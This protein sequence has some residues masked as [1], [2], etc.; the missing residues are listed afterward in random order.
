[1]VHVSSFLALAAVPFAS[2]NNVLEQLAPEGQ[3]IGTNLGAQALNGFSIVSTAREAAA[4]IFSCLIVGLCAHSLGIGGTVTLRSKPGKATKVPRGA[5]KMDDDAQVKSHSRMVTPPAN[6]GSDRLAAAASSLVGEIYA[7]NAAKLPQMLDKV[8]RRIGG[9][10]VEPK[11]RDARAAQLLLSCV[12]ACAGKRCFREAI[13]AYDHF[14]HL[15]GDG[16]GTTWS[17]LLWSAVETGCWDRSSFFAKKLRASGEISQNDIVNLVRCV[18]YRWDLDEF[19]AILDE[20]NVAGVKLDVVTRN[21]TLAV[22]TSSGAMDF[23]AELVSRTADVPLDVITYN[24]LMKGYLL[25]EKP[26][27]CIRLYEQMRSDDVGPSDVTFGI[28]LD[29]CVGG[30]LLEE[31]KR[32]LD[33]LKASELVVNVVHYT[34]FIKGLVSA[35]SLSDAR[36][37]LAEMH[38]SPHTKPDMIAYSTLAKAYSDFGHVDDGIHLWRMMRSQGVEPDVILFNMVLRACCVNPVGGLKIREVFDQAM[39]FGFKPTSSTYSVL[40][41]ACA[42]SWCWALALD[43][44]RCA[45]SHFQVWPEARVYTQLAQA[46]ASAGAS[47]EVLIT[48]SLLIQASRERGEVVDAATN[49]HFARL[50]TYCGLSS[51]A[52]SRV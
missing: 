52:L 41:K 43:F 6:T 44:I 36:D 11:M 27:L 32:V 22:F 30:S 4:I 42:K 7:G 24:T 23:A 19:V 29:A 25:A 35:G 17:L 5:K 46:C 2:T 3:N 8:M 12:R 9:V 51:D 1:M 15:I 39:V 47:S 45:P 20:C 10:G 37:V 16:C 18:A 38:N 21:R 26:Q 31:A 50:F 40:I 33:D 34:T 48:Y 14:A 28:L 13:V 49:M